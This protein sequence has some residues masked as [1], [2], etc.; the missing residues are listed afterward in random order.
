MP[1]QRVTKT[2]RRVTVT[3][4]RVSD[5]RSG[6]QINLTNGVGKKT[7]ETRKS[8]QITIRFR[9]RHKRQPSRAT[10]ARSACENSKKYLK[11]TSVMTSGVLGY[12]RPGIGPDLRAHNLGWKSLKGRPYKQATAALDTIIYWVRVWVRMYVWTSRHGS[13]S[14]R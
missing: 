7:D 8:A 6:R 11:V 2:W 14:E 4:Q 1:Q 3:W 5:L 10:D 9:W 12:R 13:M